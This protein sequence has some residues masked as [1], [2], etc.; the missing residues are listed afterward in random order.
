[1]DF[2]QSD[3]SLA[4]VWDVIQNPG[5]SILGDFWRV[6]APLAKNSSGIFFQR[7]GCLGMRY[8]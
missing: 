5:V 7:K 3:V 1:M 8:F 4:K 2:W 6:G